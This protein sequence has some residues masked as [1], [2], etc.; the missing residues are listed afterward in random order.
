MGIDI[1]NGLQMQCIGCGLCID[2]CD[3]VMYKINKP[4]GLISYAS[5][6]STAKLRSGT[7]ISMKLLR[8]KLI[9]YGLMILI[10]SAVILKNLLNKSMFILSVERERGP[11]FTVTPDGGN[12]YNIYS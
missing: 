9:L 10:A 4:L 8:P 6:N 11:L 5:V 1:R 2:A 3:S 12:T 7:K